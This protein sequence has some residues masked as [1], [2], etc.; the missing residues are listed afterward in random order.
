MK[1][2]RNTGEDDILARLMAEY[3]EQE[4]A[5]L[6][7]E[8]EEARAGG[9]APQMP[10]STDRKC[11]RRIEGEFARQKAQALGKPLLKFAERAAAA[12]IVGAWYDGGAASEEDPE[13]L[14]AMLNEGQPEE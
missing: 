14:R 5:R 8:F 3:A 2:E 4:G 1:K 10:E 12:V 9:E 13:E 7:R 11:R 6:W